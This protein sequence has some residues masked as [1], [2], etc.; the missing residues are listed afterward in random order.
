MIEQT[1]HNVFGYGEFRPGQRPV[2]EAVTVGLCGAGRAGVTRRKH[3]TN[4]CTGESLRCAVRGI[5]TYTPYAAVP[6]RRAPCASSR[7][8]I[9][10]ALPESVD[11]SSPTAVIVA[12]RRP[13]GPPGVGRHDPARG[14]W[15]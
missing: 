3:C 13:P 11:D 6:V 2:I 12:Y 5:L 15:H 9:C 1:L 7:S 8:P 4:A 10:S 14:S